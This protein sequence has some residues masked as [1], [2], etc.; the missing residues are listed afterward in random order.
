MVGAS[1]TSWLL[2]TEA[3]FHRTVRPRNGCVVSCTHGRAC[4]GK[5]RSGS[6]R[7]DRR[8]GRGSGERAPRITLLS[9]GPRPTSAQPQ[10]RPHP[11]CQSE[12]SYPI[13]LPPQIT[14]LM[15]SQAH[16]YVNVFLNACAFVCGQGLSCTQRQ[17]AVGLAGF[18]P[19]VGSA[20]L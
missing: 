14:V 9:P 2:P 12:P 13:S 20:W 3:S 4:S 11:V 15:G 10:A 17:G 19:A 18:L 5:H 6:H 1:V 7:V 8:G 16:L